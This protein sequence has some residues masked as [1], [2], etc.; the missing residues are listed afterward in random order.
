MINTNEKHPRGLYLLCFT[1]LWERFGFYTIQTIL[2]LYMTKA[3]KMADQQANLHY[4]V[5]GSLVY[6]TPV[7]GGYLADRYLGFQRSIVIG[8]LLFIAAY[9]ICALPGQSSLF[10]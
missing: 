2:I 6:L 3:L 5:F 7:I 10:L 4:A 8:G 9:I 1:E